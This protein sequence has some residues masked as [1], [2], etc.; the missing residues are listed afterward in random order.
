MELLHQGFIRQTK[1]LQKRAICTIHN[2]SFNSHTDPT[3]RNSKLLLKLQDIFEYQSLLFIYAYFNNKLPSSFGDKLTFGVT[4]LIYTS[5][6]QR[7]YRVL[8]FLWSDFS[9]T[10]SWL[11]IFFS[12]DDKFPKIDDVLSCRDARQSANLF[13]PSFY[14]KYTQTLP[15]YHLPKL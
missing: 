5:V 14:L 12:F 1:L 11:S 2:A 15:A 7:C 9:V 13:V 3:F 8:I 6:W 4:R 10:K